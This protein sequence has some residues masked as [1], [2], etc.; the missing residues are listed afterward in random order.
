MD[1]GMIGTKQVLNWFTVNV[2]L[3]VC[4]SKVVIKGKCATSFLGQFATTRPQ[5]TLRD[6]PGK[7]LGY[8]DQTCGGKFHPKMVG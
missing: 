4:T 3:E 5:Q 8:L 6:L 7:T 1:F 2:R